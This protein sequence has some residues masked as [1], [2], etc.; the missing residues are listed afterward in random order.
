[1]AMKPVV[2]TMVALALATAS[3]KRA[4]LLKEATVS[5]SEALDKARG[6]AKDGVPVAAKLKR[7]KTGGV[8]F[9]IDFARGQSTLSVTVDPRTAAVL[10]KAERRA[11]ASKAAGA[12]KVSIAKA[13]EI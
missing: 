5:L 9:A 4:D 8:V 12:A 7:E 13:V 3:G 2:M 11:D 10:S 1:M 6:E